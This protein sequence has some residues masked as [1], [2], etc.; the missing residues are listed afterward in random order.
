MVLGGSHRSV[1]NLENPYLKCFFKSCKNIG[2]LSRLSYLL[3]IHICASLYFTMVHPYL[4]YCSIIWASNYPARLKAL[5]MLQKRAL[6]IIVG[7]SYFASAEPLFK[8][9]NI[10]RQA[11]ATLSNC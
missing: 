10:L 2:I 8:S 11:A 9:I 6:R 5:E 4:S 1:F 7:C 3:P